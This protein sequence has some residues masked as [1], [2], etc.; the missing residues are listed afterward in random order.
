M[1]FGNKFVLL[2]F[3][4]VTVNC[5]QATLHNYDANNDHTQAHTLCVLPFLINCLLS[6]ARLILQEIIKSKHQYQN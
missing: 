2:G 4:D 1:N 6:T 3:V 5:R